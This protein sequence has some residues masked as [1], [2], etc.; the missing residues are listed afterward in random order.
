MRVDGGLKDV[1]EGVTMGLSMGLSMG[2]S[3]GVSKGVSKGVSVG[4]SVGVGL[5]ENGWPNAVSRFHER[6]I[7]AIRCLFFNPP[8]SALEATH[9]LGGVLVGRSIGRNALPVRTRGRASHRLAASF[10]GV[11]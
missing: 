11:L 4:V 1:T 8:A 3:M 2:V 5:Y 6:W 9:R 7:K 10:D